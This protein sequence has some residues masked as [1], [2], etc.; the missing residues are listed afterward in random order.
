M[1]D[2]C[3]T[4][5]DSERWGGLVSWFHR[6]AWQSFNWFFWVVCVNSFWRERG[7]N[8]C[9]HKL[10]SD[11]TFVF[12]GQAWI[13]FVNLSCTIYP[14]GDYDLPWSCHRFFWMFNPIQEI[15]R[16]YFGPG[17]ASLRHYADFKIKIL[18]WTHYDFLLFGNRRLLSHSWSPVQE[19]FLCQSPPVLSSIGHQRGR[20]YF[21]FVMPST[22][23]L[24]LPPAES[25]EES[26]TSCVVLCLFFLC[27]LLKVSCGWKRFNKRNNTV[28][29]NSHHQNEVF[30]AT[31]DYSLSPLRDLGDP[32]GWPSSL[33]R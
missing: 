25:A 33:H 23:C 19:Y 4:P 11:V 9:K 20:C 8:L 29:R 14:D 1:C 18:E 5:V 28:L 16:L 17:P 21:R 6:K 32:P 30:V 15:P 3:P 27:L 2:S 24:E 26:S 10:V 22:H 13:A 12:I 31:F 7:R